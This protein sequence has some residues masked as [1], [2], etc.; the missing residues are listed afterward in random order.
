MLHGQHSLFLYLK[1]Y[2]LQKIIY[3]RSRIHLATMVGKDS[4]L[5]VQWIECGSPK[6]KIRV[7]F[8]SG[9]RYGW[10]LRFSPVFLSPKM[11]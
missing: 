6:A 10:G 7:R 11:S 1:F 8:S 2:F 3:L 5:V 9:V 4:A